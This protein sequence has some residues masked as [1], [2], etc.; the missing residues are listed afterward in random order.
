MCL[1][2]IKK[3]Q[4]EKEREKEKEKEKEGRRKGYSINKQLQSKKGSSKKINI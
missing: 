3:I 1:K 4:R 2:L